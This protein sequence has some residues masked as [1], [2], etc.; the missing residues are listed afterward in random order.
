MPGTSVIVTSVKRIDNRV[1]IF[2]SKE[3]ILDISKNFFM[4]DVARS[5]SA[6]PIYF[7][8]AS[9]K[10]I[11]ATKEYSLIDG[12]L[13]LNNPSKLVI[14]EIKKAAINQG[15][16]SNYF[17]LSLGTGR[18]VQEGSIPKNA[19]LLNVAPVIDSFTE[20]SNYFI[21]RGT[22]F[23]Y[24]DIAMNYKGHY[25]RVSPV[26]NQARKDL[27]LDNTTPEI[28]KLYKK[29]G[30]DSATEY[31]SNLGIFGPY[32]DRS[33]IEWLAENTDKKYEMA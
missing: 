29:Q 23:L 16:E 17:L 19:G 25:L 8:A 26:F 4:R 32:H 10:N 30:V 11:Q 21:E 12:G 6:A 13:G 7:P 20:S 22:N 31:F 5:T 28:M 24:S 1:K 14:D 3:A 9:I 27:E 33:L 18:S 2:K 15:A